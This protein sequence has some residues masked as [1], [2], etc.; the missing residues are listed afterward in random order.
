MNDAMKAGLLNLQ[1]NINT[2]DMH[3][4]NTANFNTPEGD[5]WSVNN[6][7]RQG[8]STMNVNPDMG[9]ANTSKIRNQAMNGNMNALMNG[10]SG[11]SMS[12]LTSGFAQTIND[13]MKAGLLNL[14]NDIGTYDLHSGSTT[15]FNH[16]EGDGWS[17]N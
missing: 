6:L 13:A 10:G 17:A 1:N 5:G 15:N 14:S 12:S 3:S 11:D 9:N 8:G 4:G 16:P 2:L 7:I